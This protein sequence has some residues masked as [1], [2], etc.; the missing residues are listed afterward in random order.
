MKDPAGLNKF[1]L[2]GGHDDI[3]AKKFTQTSI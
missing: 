1:F 2:G 3:D